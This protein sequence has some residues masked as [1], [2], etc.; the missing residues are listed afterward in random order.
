MNFT[1]TEKLAIVKALSEIIAA[2]GKIDPS[3][4]NYLVHLGRVIGFE[5][6]ILNSAKEMNLKEAVTALSGMSDEKRA[7]LAV[8][9]HEMANADG[10]I[11]DS[12]LEVI[13]AVFLAAGIDITK[14]IL[15]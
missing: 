11:V 5:P 7:A 1:L 13:G 3:E 8:M 4:I 15:V 14:G 2:D 10:K 6:S 9:M 12:E